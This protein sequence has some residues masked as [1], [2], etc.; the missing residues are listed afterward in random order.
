[1]NTLVFRKKHEW[2]DREEILLISNQIRRHTLVEGRFV[3]VENGLRPIGI[4][5]MLSRERKEWTLEGRAL[6]RHEVTRR[7]PDR[8]DE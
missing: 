1:M 8:L 4:A 5:V 3:K 7:W 6:D 2:Q